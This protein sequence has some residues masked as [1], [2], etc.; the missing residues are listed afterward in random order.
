MSIISIH[1]SSSL[2][3]LSGRCWVG[4]TPRG[5]QYPALDQKSE[6]RLSH[7]SSSYRFPVLGNSPWLCKRQPKI[8]LKQSRNLTTLDDKHEGMCYTDTGGA[9]PQA[10]PI[11][12][13]YP[14][15]FVGPYLSESLNEEL[16]SCLA[17]DLV[18]FWKIKHHLQWKMLT[19]C[20]PAGQH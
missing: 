19:F 5:R 16:R 9:V 17:E 15:F 18:K 13:D 1:L 20:Y 10:K 6:W 7:C 11:G 4:W 3:G 14:Y 8:P 2:A 12:W